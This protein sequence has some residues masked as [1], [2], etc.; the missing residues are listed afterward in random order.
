MSALQRGTV[1]QSTAAI[2]QIPLN[3]VITSDDELTGVSE[4][5]MPNRYRPIEPQGSLLLS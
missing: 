4:G 3:P 2:I 5:V 1:L